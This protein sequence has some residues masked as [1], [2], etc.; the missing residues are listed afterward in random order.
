[1]VSSTL[2]RKPRTYLMDMDG[3]LVRG[4]QLIP[5]ADVFILS[6]VAEIQP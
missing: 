3:V 1:M 5:G 6:S 4:S 2:P